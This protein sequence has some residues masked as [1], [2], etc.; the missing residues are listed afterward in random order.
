MSSSNLD[1][2]T[3]YCP[4]TAASCKIPIFQ[5]GVMYVRAMVGSGSGQ[6]LEQASARVNVQ[7][8]KLIA[9]CDRDLSVDKTRL[10]GDVLC[11][12]SLSENLPF[13]ITERSSLADTFPIVDGP[14]N[15]QV[16]AGESD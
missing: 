12:A 15:V 10:G 5:S 14:L 8:P 9:I 3:V 4:A 7:D 13:R 16:P 6:V 2:R 1:P 11:E